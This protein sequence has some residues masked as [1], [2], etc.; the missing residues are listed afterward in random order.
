M[1]KQKLA[2]ADFEAQIEAISKA[3]AVIHFNMDG[4]IVTANENFLNTL[5]YTSSEVIGRH[6]SMFVEP[7]FKASSEYR[8]FWERLNRG[9][10]ESKEYK[11]IGKG[12]KEVWIQA[13][14]NPI[15]DLNGT[16]IKVVK[17][18]T[19]VTAQKLATQEISR[20]LF[21]LEQGDLTSNVGDSA[22]T[23]EFKAVGDALN[24][25]LEKLRDTVSRIDEAAHGLKSN[26]SSIK[27]GNL[28]LSQRT[29]EQATALEETAAT[30]EEF[31]S[32]VRQNA[33]HATQ[34]N[35]LSSEARSHAEKG[36][37][38][39]GNAISAM[40]EINDASKKIEDIIGVIDE[41]AF[42]TN[43]LALKRCRR[44]GA[45]RR[46][47]ARV[48]GCSKRSEESC[49]AERECCQGNQGSDQG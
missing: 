28:N 2:N 37:A 35:E 33:E 7:S 19:D 1:T 18:A 36:G 48:R 41:I 16:P 40:G 8:E 6:H 9:E 17:Y 20:V 47:R 23:G 46:R 30:I 44:S 15:L 38:V 24:G 12:G 10:Y 11:R 42:Q 49:S 43:L 39:V 45:C 32:A 21:E 22:R 4:T 5:G 13:S 25:T 26:S 3:Q 27:D 14:Y 34:A 31:T 29:E